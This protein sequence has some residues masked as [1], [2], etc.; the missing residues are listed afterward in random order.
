MIFRHEKNHCGKKN[1]TP[2]PA[3]RPGK[4]GKG[5]RRG[6]GSVVWFV[7]P[8]RHLPLLVFLFA[9]VAV[10]SRVW[11]TE[12]AYITFRAVE[13]F[14][15]G[16]GPL[17]NP[18]ER[19]EVFTHP[20]WFALLFLLRAF[21]IPLHQGV[22][23]LGLLL[24]LGGIALLVRRNNATLPFAAL[25]LA[26]NSGF[27]D[28]ST[29]GLEF[30]LVFFLLVI[31]FRDLEDFRLAEKPERFAVILSLLYMTRPELAL[32]GV[33]YS[34]FF[35]LEVIPA[36]H[37]FDERGPIR[38]RLKQT[39]LLLVR[40]GLPFVVLGGGM[41]LFRFLYFGELFTNT[42]YAKA[43][44]AS[45]PLQGAKYVLYSILWSPSV[46]P[47]LFLG[48]A[49]PLLHKVRRLLPADLQG[50]HV[51]ELG[52]I[53]LL[54]LYIIRVGGDFM[55]FRMFLPEIVM[56][57]LLVDRFIVRWELGT[58]LRPA[59]AVLA[60]SIFI[61]VPFQKGWVAD[62]RKVFAGDE[63]VGALFSGTNY[64]WG[65]RGA[66]YGE[67]ARCLGLDALWISNSQ[68]QAHCMKG[69]GL[70]YFGVAA[71]PRV[72]II[73]EQGLPD[74]ETARQT[75]LVR[76]RPG[77]E[78]YADLTYVL[79]RR[80]IFCSS[81][82]PE[83]DR[84]MSTGAGIVLNLDPR[85]VLTLPDA[86]D[87]LRTLTRLKKEGSPIVR[88]LEERDGIAVEELA[89]SAA[90]RSSFLASKEQCWRNF[91]SAPGEDFEF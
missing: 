65:K 58:L 74:H 88:R 47:A 11:V 14:Y 86:A 36:R 23:V 33:W 52:L 15:S 69:A 40:W 73:D 29:S 55:S 38:V 87:R 10:A 50:R 39:A 22:I 30:S 18:G 31:L 42:Y 4:K 5:C 91:R 53:V 26:A 54:S 16:Y 20:T 3:R 64:E 2:N 43:G 89:R 27:R 85:I 34:A 60:L 79:K 77:H 56:L 17:Y 67:L 9:L 44:L 71:G 66:R 46:W 19:V 78:H 7:L 35:L 81:G 72:R 62:E 68:A 41:H 6:A 25:A 82:E 84:A 24:T 76:W 75:V 83:Y 32:M 57:C 70:G 13:N 49:V 48:F 59:A 61:P 90:D 80:A 37:P 45:H 63:P 21:A 12:D 8:A 1:D 51:R 28:F